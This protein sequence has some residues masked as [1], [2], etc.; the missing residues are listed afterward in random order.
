M[1]MSPW[2][3]R[4]TVSGTLL[5]CFWDIATELPGHKA[6]IAGAALTSPGRYD[7]F[8]TLFAL[9]NGAKGKAAHV[10]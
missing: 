9:L 5:F 7:C 3:K 2:V 4:V 6:K 1:T 10:D 8:P